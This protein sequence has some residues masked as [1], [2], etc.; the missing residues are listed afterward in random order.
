MA[1]LRRA[2]HYYGVDQRFSQADTCGAYLSMATVAYPPG[3]PPARARR[4]ASSRDVVLAYRSPRMEMERDIERGTRE[5]DEQSAAPVPRNRR[6]S[7]GEAAAINA[8]RKPL[9]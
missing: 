5:T 8:S 1:I 9:E 3:L 7:A 6:I 4:P 2:I